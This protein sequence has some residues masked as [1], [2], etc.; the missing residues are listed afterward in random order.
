MMKRYS[1]K[2]L[3]QFKVIIGSD[4]GK[5]RLCEERIVLLSARDAHSALTKAKIRGKTSQH[6][7]MNS[8]GNPVHFEFVGVMDLLE[9][10]AECDP[11]EVWYELNERLLPSERR[12]KFIPPESQLNALRR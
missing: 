9:L 1:A 2:L 12:E 6:R 5:R 11:D 3:F 4:P 7:Y 10:G 8:D